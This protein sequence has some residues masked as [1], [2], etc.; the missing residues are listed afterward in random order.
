[1]PVIILKKWFRPVGTDQA[2]NHAF[3]RVK[4][5][6]LTATRPPN[7]LVSRYTSNSGIIDLASPE[8]HH[9]P[10]KFRLTFHWVQALRADDHH[11]H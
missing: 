4:S 1:M 5:T 7:R 3:S 9:R 10:V 8:T 6:E 11:H 2:G